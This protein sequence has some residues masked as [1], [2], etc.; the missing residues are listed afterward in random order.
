MVSMLHQQR[1]GYLHRG[2]GETVLICCAQESHLPTLIR[3]R[4]LTLDRLT[5]IVQLQQQL[6]VAPLTILAPESHLLPVGLPETEVLLA[7]AFLHLPPIS[8]E[9]H[10]LRWHLSSQQVS[11]GVDLCLVS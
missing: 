7:E 8:N 10:V 1:S 5:P 3:E 11:A 4:L 2:H 6:L 9:V